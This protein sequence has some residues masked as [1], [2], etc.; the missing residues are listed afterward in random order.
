MNDIM[1][2]FG[3]D[4]FTVINIDRIK[5]E[6]NHFYNYLENRKLSGMQIDLEEKNTLKRID[7]N[8]LMSSAKSVICVFFPYLSEKHQLNTNLSVSAQGEDY[9]IWG[10][11][12]LKN[13]A[14]ML[15][16]QNLDSNYLIQVD[17]GPVNERF[18]A[19]KSGLGLRGLNN[20]VIN[21]KYG[22]YGFIGIIITDCLFEE[23][24]IIAGNC[25]MCKACI[26][27]CPGNAI[28]EN[29][30]LDIKKCASY[31]SQ[32]KLD[33]NEY[34]ELILKK[35]KK[36]YGC[37]ICQNVCIDNKYAKKIS[38]DENLITQ[39]KISDINNI[40]NKEFKK[41]YGDRAFAWRGKNILL[42]NLDIV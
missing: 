34:E 26:N 27:A 38:L 33:L 36:I 40:S 14:N 29:F 8:L 31:I 15:K 42:R 41:I 37:D 2:S 10:K 3:I 30:T 17:N 13:I 11:E 1:N 20:M 23:K 39:L 9:H 5:G 35:S 6:I 24:S 22:S 12:K 21:P 28:N 32:K 19:L 16:K 7:V 4:Q 25:S 18:F